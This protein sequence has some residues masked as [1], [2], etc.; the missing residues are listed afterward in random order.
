VGASKKP[1]TEAVAGVRSTVDSSTP[2]TESDI[3][4]RNFAWPV[5]RG[6]SFIF[7]NMYV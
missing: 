4:P 2:D 6:T 1:S 3:S 5:G 7:S